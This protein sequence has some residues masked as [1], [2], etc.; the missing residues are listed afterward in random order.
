MNKAIQTALTNAV[1][2]RVWE[3]PT[4]AQIQEASQ[5]VETLFND[6]GLVLGIPGI[7]ARSHQAVIYDEAIRRLTDATGQTD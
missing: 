4:A 1:V 7:S 5:M 3:H 2:E 6:D